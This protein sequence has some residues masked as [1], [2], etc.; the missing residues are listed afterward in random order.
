MSVIDHHVFDL[1]QRVRKLLNQKEPWITHSTKHLV[2][3]VIH[4][5]W[6]FLMNFL[7]SSILY[8]IYLSILLIKFLCLIPN[9]Y[10][11]SHFI[12]FFSF[13]FARKSLKKKKNLLWVLG[14][15]NSF[16]III[17]FP[18]ISK[19]KMVILI[20]FSSIIFMKAGALQKPQ[21]EFT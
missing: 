10:F 6:T 16:L 18:F 19:I 9:L 5:Y 2:F 17:W 11:S 14:I 8:F 21:N 4:S 1:R 13:C 3:P 20:N 12:F 15:F 7:L